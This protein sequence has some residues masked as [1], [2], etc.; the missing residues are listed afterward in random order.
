VNY[1]DPTGHFTEEEL[2]KFFDGWRT[3]SKLL[4]DMLLMDSTTWGTVLNFGNSGDEVAVLSVMVV[5]EQAEYGRNAF[6]GR[7]MDVAGDT[8]GWYWESSSTLSK[9]SHGS[10]WIPTEYGFAEPRNSKLVLGDRHLDAGANVVPERTRWQQW[11]GPGVGL[12]TYV[13][14][15]DERFLLTF[16]SVG[17]DYLTE[18]LLN[19]LKYGDLNKAVAAVGASYIDASYPA[20]LLGQQLLPYSGNENTIT[21]P[22][23]M[24]SDAIGPQP[25]WKR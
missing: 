14:R 8:N 13:D 23:P 18:L 9:Y 20:I 15:N 24:W 6:F 10:V 3:W 17:T 1:T 16:V 5:L 12:G 21:N 19:V 2:D 25:V 7:F 11:L 4:Q 22:P